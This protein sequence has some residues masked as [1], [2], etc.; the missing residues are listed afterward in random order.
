MS[1][2]VNSGECGPFAAIFNYIMCFVS[3]STFCSVKCILHFSGDMCNGGHGLENVVS[4][5]LW[6][7]G[8]MT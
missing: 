3:D 8:P 5:A 6:P 2:S 7:E 1:A 4:D